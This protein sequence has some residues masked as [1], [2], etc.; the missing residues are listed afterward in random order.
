MFLP[1]ANLWTRLRRETSSGRFIPQVDGL[2]FFAI[3]GVLVFHI[4]EYLQPRLAIESTG[5]GLD[6]LVD[7]VASQGFVGVQLF[8]A[9][10]GFIL[11]L[12]FAEAHLAGR[13]RPRLR[14]YFARRVTRLEPP[15]F[16]NLLVMY[17][18]Y[19]VLAGG[20]GALLPHLLASMGYVHNVVY[21]ARSAVN[22]VAWS[23]EIEVQFYVVA[24]L[25]AMVFRLRSTILRRALLAGSIALL[26]LQNATAVGPWNLTLANHL[27]YF[28]VGF[29]LA[30]FY[31]TQ[32]RD[33]RRPRFAWDV[34]GTLV[35]A[36]IVAVVY[37]QTFPRELLP[38]LIAVAYAAA[39]RGPVWRRITGSAALVAIGGMCYSIYLWHL[40]IYPTVASA[41]APFVVGSSYWAN[42][43][44]Q[45]A[46]VGMVTLVPCA[47]LFLLL[48]KPFMS[49]DWPA[50]L[51]ASVALF[52]FRRHA[53]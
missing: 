20:G 47:L 51:R 46:V 4:H 31:L 26:S 45:T 36:G 19:G 3:A 13:P 9:I 5:R 43:L 32:W 33:D 30:D 48:E 24:P 53:T 25:L 38:P 27:Q 17:L 37:W 8:F 12:P 16:A 40:L 11:A 41:T 18:V 21:G 2:R 14:K 15:Y 6:A 39:F 22:G 35:W 7:G 52:V 28:L 49:R 29:L 23:L 44:A 34:A 42:M 1:M 10:S 50:R